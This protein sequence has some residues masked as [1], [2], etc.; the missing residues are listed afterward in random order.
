MKKGYKVLS[1]LL[2]LCLC[3]SLLPS[4]ALAADGEMAGKTVVLYTGNLRGDVDVY[5]KVAAVKADYE[6]KGADVILADAGNYLQGSA[7]ANSDRGLGVYNLMDAAGYD[8]AAMGMYEFVYGDAS[9]GYVYHSNFFKF[10]TQAELLNGAAEITYPQNGKG[11]VT[12]TR[13]EKAP[14]AFAVVS[15]N[16]TGSASYYAFSANKTITTDSGLTVGFFGLTDPATADNVQD[17]FVEGLAFGAAADAANAQVAALKD[18]D[19]IV[20]LSNAGITAVDGAVVLAADTNGDEVVGALVIDNQTKVVSNEAVDLTATAADE[21]VAAAAAALKEAA[22]TAVAKSR[23][24]LNGSDSVNWNSESN[25]G[26]LTAD[27]LKWYAGKYI[28]GIDQSIE[29]VAIQNGGNCDNFLYSGDITANDLLKALPFSP[30]GVGVLYVTG[31]QLLEA[32]EAA[33]CPSDSY[34][35]A[36]PGFAQVSGLEYTVAAYKDYDAGEEYG[37]FH[38]ADSIN[39]VTITSVNGKAFDASATYAVVADNFVLNGSDTYY[40]FK[41]A[42]EA[43][44]AAYINNGPGI[45]T[46]DIVA[47]YVNEVLGGTIGEDYAQPQGRI[48]VLTEEPPIVLPFTDVKE[49][50]WYYDAVAYVYKTGLMVGTEKTRFEPNVVLSR[51]MIVTMLYRIA[52]TPEITAGQNIPFTDVASD[53]WYYDAVAWAYGEG[54]TFGTSETTFDPNHSVTREQLAAFF[55]RYDGNPE[56]TAT[57]TYADAAAVSSWAIDAVAYCTAEGILNGMGNNQFVPKGT[58]T[59]AQGAQILT[60]YFA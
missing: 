35:S 4:L 29:L 18:S 39:R 23:V 17:A 54:I 44:G 28:D 6:A 11:D 57:V 26:D 58:A 25:L 37:K 42:K 1:L 59:R 8:I 55:Y 19:V 47:L 14:A 40:V 12:A 38:K 33:T 56:T 49:N 50:A 48:T 3:L 27:A 9:V 51:A 36:C 2:A 52:G 7:A 10:Y 30:M 13:A 15:A 60:N 53:A 32:L 41:E 45:K 34:G 20:C 31:G 16:V 21:T 24:S 46:R 22:G 43:E 5:A